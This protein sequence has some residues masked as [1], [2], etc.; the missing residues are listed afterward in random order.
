MK[1]VLV[2]L[3]LLG[4]CAPTS[5][6]RVVEYGGGGAAGLFTGGVGGCSVYQ[7]KDSKLVAPFRI[8]YKGD[9]CVVDVGAE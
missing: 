6:V 1:T 7:S 2:L 3:L 8:V 5:M 4:G 9:K